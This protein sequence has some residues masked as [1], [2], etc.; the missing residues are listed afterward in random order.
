MPACAKNRL[1]VKEKRF[2]GRGNARTA[3][4]FIFP[5]AAATMRH[6]EEISC[7][8]L[9]ARRQALSKAETA[10]EKYS[11]EGQVETERKTAPERMASPLQEKTIPSFLQ[12][13]KKLMTKSLFI[14]NRSSCGPRIR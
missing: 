1:P 11:P 5:P 9:S 3:W 14:R 10:K 8:L 13:S 7:Q 4:R 12:Q 6:T 2:I